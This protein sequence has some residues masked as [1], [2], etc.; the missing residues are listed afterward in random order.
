[1]NVERLKERFDR[2]MIP[3][4]HFTEGIMLNR[5]QTDRITDELIKEKANNGRTVK[6]LIAENTLK[7]EIAHGEL[8]KKLEVQGVTVKFNN[9]F[10]MGLIRTGIIL[11][12]SIILALIG[13]AAKIIFERLV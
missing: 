4:S 11:G 3:T 8:D 1:M 5:R 7:N 12:S 6:E 13:W 10:I 2:W 9:R